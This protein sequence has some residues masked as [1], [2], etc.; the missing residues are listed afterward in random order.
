MA[1]VSYWK[2]SRA[3]KPA[4]MTSRRG[5]FV[6]VVAIFGL[7]FLALPVFLVLP[8]SISGSS[9][10]SFPPDGFSSQWYSKLLEESGWRDAFFT[11]VWLG[12]LVSLIST[13]VGGLG[14][15]ALVRMGTPLARV[16]TLN[17]LAP[18]VMPQIVTAVA[19][20]IAFAKMGILGTP[21]GL[22]IAHVVLAMPY[23]VLVM[24]VAV[25]S[26]DIRLEKAAQ[27]L[28]ASKLTVIR[29]V[30]FPLLKP[31]VAAAALFAFVISFDEAVVTLFVAGAQTTI[32]KRI[33][34]EIVT[35]IDPTIAAVSSVLIGFSILLLATSAILLRRQRAEQERGL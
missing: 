1:G 32:P 31:S 4:D 33:F 29:T 15:Y 2:G 30:T 9:T 34:T 7:L 21:L 26:L 35:K 11:S 20:Y 3:K 16:L 14:A 17:T 5:L 22:V 13:L 18:L 28:G 6:T 24:S 27:S 19:L 8:M 23:V 10:L 12:V 25:G